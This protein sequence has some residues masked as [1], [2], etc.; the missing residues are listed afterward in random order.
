L[1]ILKVKVV[2]PKGIAYVFFGLLAI[3]LLILYLAVL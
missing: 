1:G 2:K 3:G